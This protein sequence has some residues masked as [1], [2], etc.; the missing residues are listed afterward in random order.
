MVLAGRHSDRT[1]ERR[2]HVGLS[3]LAAAAGFALSGLPGLPPICVMGMLA[4]AISGVMSPAACFWALPTAILS[5]TAA[6]AG[7]AWINSVGNLA[8]Y[9][10]PEMVAWLKQRYGMSMALNGVAVMLVVSSLTALF[11]G[12]GA[13]TKGIIRPSP[14]P[15]D[16]PALSR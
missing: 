4:I 2:W 15:V 5:G 10:S 1:G 11:S 14:T 13:P 12:V 9:L 8:G 6:A 7:I 16:T 3:T